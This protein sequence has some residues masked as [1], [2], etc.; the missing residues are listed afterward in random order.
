MQYRQR[1]RRGDVRGA[2]DRRVT[3]RIAYT[4]R[5]GDEAVD[6]AHNRPDAVLRKR[7]GEEFDAM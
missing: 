6:D 5:N 7:M 3:R 2:R 4:E 1:I